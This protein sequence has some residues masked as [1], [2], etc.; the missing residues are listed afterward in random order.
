[1]IAGE[2]VDWPVTPQ[3]ASTGNV[4]AVL[5]TTTPSWLRRVVAGHRHPWRPKHDGHRDQSPERRRASR[6]GP[7]TSNRD[8]TELPVRLEDELTTDQAALCRAHLN[9]IP[10]VKVMNQLDYWSR[11]ADPQKQLWSRPGVPRET[12]LKLEANKLYLPGVELEMAFC[13]PLSRW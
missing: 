3:F 6:P 7:T 4:L 13:A 12:A 10:G 11:T 8:D 9:E 5:L 2:V 1:M